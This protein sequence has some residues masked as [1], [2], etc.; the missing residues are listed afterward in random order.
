[1]GAPASVGRG[2]RKTGDD[3]TVTAISL[4]YVVPELLLQNSYLT[5]TPSSLDGGRLRCIRLNLLCPCCAA[6]RESDRPRR[7]GQSNAGGLQV[8]ELLARRFNSMGG[9]ELL[10]CREAERSSL[11]TNCRR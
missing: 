2:R 8:A 10:S 9:S 7:D 1:M 5:P 6:W 4:P 3:A 11:A